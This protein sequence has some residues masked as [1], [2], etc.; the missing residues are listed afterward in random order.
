M[1]DGCN[2]FR[3]HEWGPELEG[4]PRLGGCRILWSAERNAAVVVRTAGFATEGMALPHYRTTA[5]S[6]L[7]T[8]RP[9]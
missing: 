9:G 5:L 7:V 3:E 2:D 6:A 1:N 8:L 4:T